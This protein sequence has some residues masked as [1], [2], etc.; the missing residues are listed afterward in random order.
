PAGGY[1]DPVRETPGFRAGLIVSIRDLED[2]G[3]MPADL[4]RRLA[5]VRL[6]A[7]VRR[8][9]E[10]VAGIFESYERE[11][12]ARRLY[13]RSELLARAAEAPGAAVRGVSG[14]PSGS[15]GDGPFLVYGFYDL[16]ELQWR[17]FQAPAPAAAAVA[18]PPPR[19]G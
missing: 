2:A 6:E 15:G 14:A 16:N 13:D 19:G 5:S 4:R 18:L 7:D 9:L 3:W 10:S 8:K 12:V 17:L 11:R 1:F